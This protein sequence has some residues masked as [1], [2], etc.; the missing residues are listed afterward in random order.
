[1]PYKIV[2]E[3]GP[4]PWKIVNKITGKVVG[5]SVTKKNAEA[6]IRARFMGEY[7]KKKVHKD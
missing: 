2:K 1:M 6:S 4:R 5:S 3:S 7:G